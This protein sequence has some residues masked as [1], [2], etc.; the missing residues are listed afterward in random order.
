MRACNFVSV[1]IAISLSAS[2][3]G[4]SIEALVL[5]PF[6]TTDRLV[7]NEPPSSDRREV[8]VLLMLQRGP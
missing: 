3:N 4:R 8:E 1:R 2:Q 7:S 5:C 6:T